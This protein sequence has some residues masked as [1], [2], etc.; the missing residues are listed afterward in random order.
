MKKVMF[1]VVIVSLLVALF[2]V[3]TFAGPTEYVG[4]L[5]DV[6]CAAKGT[7][8]DGANLQTNPEKHTAA[9]MKMPGCA[10]SGYGI[11]VKAEKGGNYVFHKFDEKGNEIAKKLLNTTKRADNMHIKVTGVMSKDVI[12]VETIV[13]Q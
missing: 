3:V 12:K 10:A 2:Q 13:E 6:K 9:C 4:Y 5:S 11:L 8:G 1:S 7:A